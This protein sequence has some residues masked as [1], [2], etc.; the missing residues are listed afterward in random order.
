M[1]WILCGKNDAAVTILEFLIEQG[2]EVHVV[3]TRGDDG[4]D[5]WQR[6]LVGAA[7]RLG[8]PVECPRRIN[9][10]GFVAKLAGLSARALVSVQY[11]QILKDPLFES[12]GCPSLNLHFSLLP[13]HRGVAPIAWAIL[14]GDTR[15]GTS[16]HHMVEAIDA[17]DVLAQRAVSLDPEDTA[18]DLYDKVSSAAS[19]LFRECYPL[20]DELLGRRLVQDAAVACYHKGGDFDFSERSVDWSRPV[21]ELH[22]WLRA[23]I[24]PPM[25]YP[26]TH[27]EGRAWTLRRLAP[28]VGARAASP[29]GTVLAS[30]PDGVEVA[31]AGGTIRITDLIPLEA[32]DAAAPAVGD[33][34]V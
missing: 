23:M 8:V 12:I 14:E 20:P 2:D 15:A 24:F 29:P 30:G 17:G 28:Q 6:S 25:Q 9:D 16:L 27:I 7:G 21:D 11:D 1:R 22:R 34:F 33:R 4:K 5:G 3:A 19:G 10:P 13:R 31:A 32:S 26:Q 18:R